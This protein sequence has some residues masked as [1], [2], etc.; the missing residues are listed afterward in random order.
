MR[1]Y[2][3]IRMVEYSIALSTNCVFKFAVIKTRDRNN[4]KSRSFAN[5]AFNSNISFSPWR[6]IQE[7]DIVAS[8]HCDMEQL[9]LFSKNCFYVHYLVAFHPRL[10]SFDDIYAGRN[11]TKKTKNKR[12]F[13]NILT[14]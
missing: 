14:N 10:L 4:L 1:L 5:M 12:V 3:V 9:I 13:L 8:L 11:F 6:H 7:I 2:D